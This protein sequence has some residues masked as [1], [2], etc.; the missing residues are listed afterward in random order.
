MDRIKL[1][2]RLAAIERLVPDGARLA[3]V[4]TD[5]GLLP[6][7]LLL[8][9]RIASAVATDIRPGP[10]EKARANAARYGVENLRLL[11]CDGL[12]GIGPEEADTVVIAGMGGET[13]AGILA[14]APWAAGA[15]LILQPMSR[16]EAL[17]AALPG[18]GLA[19]T[20]EFLVEDA[21]RLYP[22]LTACG[23]AAAPCSPG[24]LYTGRWEWVRQDPLAGRLLDQLL[25]RLGAAAAGL[26][27]SG[28]E[29]DRQRL[30]HIQCVLD[31]LEYR[32]RLYHAGCFRR[33]GVPG[34]EGAPGAENGL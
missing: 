4:G 34:A 8:S 11:L 2:P 21:G 6:I 28:R 33:S 7:A 12:S 17:R 23:G 3:D 22:V 16:P 9:G 1:P 19:V 30:R 24:E 25:S 5:H 13:V 31:E 20:G 18:L 15:R 26:R 14:A 27:Q 29:E 10:L 32:R